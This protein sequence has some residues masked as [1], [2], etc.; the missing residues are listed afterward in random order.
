MLAEALSTLDDK[1]ELNNQM[2]KTL[3]AIGK[4]FFKHWFI[5]FEFPNEEDKSYRSSGGEMVHNEELGRKLPRDWRMA[6]LG[7]FISILE[8]GSRPTGGVKNIEEGI[9]SVGAESIAQL[10]VFDFSITKFVDKDFFEGMRAGH[11]ENGDIFLYKDGGKPGQHPGKKTMVDQGFPFD[12][13]CINEHVYRLRVSP[14]LT[15]HYL[16][17]WLDTPYATEQIIQRAT[18]VA[19]PGLNRQAVQD[20]PILIPTNDTVSEFT[21]IAQPLCDRIFRNS[22]ESHALAQI[23]DSLLPK[24]MSGKI[25]V[26]VKVG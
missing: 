9:P 26:P 3:E 13:F 18:G 1:I 11:V 17:F 6:V 4:A 23:R 24:L 10:G 19:Q 15:Q 16:Y 5:D 20:I 21:A 22:K 12:R 7:D 8:T 25:R 2:C 14:P